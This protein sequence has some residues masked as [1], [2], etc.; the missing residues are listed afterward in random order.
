MSPVR[1]GSAV[2]PTGPRASFT[3]IPTITV[4]D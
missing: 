4:S 3:L 1:M 2:F